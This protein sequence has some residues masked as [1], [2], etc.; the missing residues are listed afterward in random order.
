MCTAPRRS[1]KLLSLLFDNF[2]LRY[3]QPSNAYFPTANSL[4][5]IEKGMTTQTV[6]Y[7]DMTTK[8]QLHNFHDIHM[9]VVS[10]VVSTSFLF[11]LG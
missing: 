1:V 6:A 3:N 8:R 9:I 11:A 10:S 2:I 5:Q 7:S 4:G